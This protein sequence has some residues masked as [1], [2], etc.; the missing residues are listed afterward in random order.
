MSFKIGSDDDTRA[1]YFEVPPE[2]FLYDVK[3]VAFKEPFCLLGI[4][5]TVDEG[6]KYVLGTTFLKNYYTIYDYDN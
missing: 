3:D 2:N 6:N 5:G 4:V 1:L